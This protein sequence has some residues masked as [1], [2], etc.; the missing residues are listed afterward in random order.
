MQDGEAIVRRN[1]FRRSA[2]TPGIDP[3]TGNAE[4]PEIDLQ[5]G[6]A[7]ILGIDPRTGVVGIPGTDTMAG[8]EGDQ[9]LRVEVKSLLMWMLLV[10]GSVSVRWRNVF[11]RHQD[12]YRI[13]KKR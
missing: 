10:V 7:E 2:G 13:L 8:M 4:I 5:R 6:D 9:T 11:Q 3:V 1:T 12:R